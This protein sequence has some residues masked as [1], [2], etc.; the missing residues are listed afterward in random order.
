MKKRNC[1]LVIKTR[2]RILHTISTHVQGSPGHVLSRGQADHAWD[3]SEHPRGLR[4][5]NDEVSALT[6]LIL[7]NLHAEVDHWKVLLLIQSLFPLWR[8]TAKHTIPGRA[9]RGHIDDL[10][11]LS[12]Y[13]LPGSSLSFTSVQVK[14][15]PQV[16]GI[17]SVQTL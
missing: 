14:T 5:L 15:C 8:C 6:P 17:S 12:G 4:I 13:D 2:N 9:F 3:Q 16:Y 11:F 1:L 7:G 10:W